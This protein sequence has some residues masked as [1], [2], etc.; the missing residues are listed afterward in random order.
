[1]QSVLTQFHNQMRSIPIGT[2]GMVTAPSMVLKRIRAG[3][4]RTRTTEPKLEVSKLAGT[5]SNCFW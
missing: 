5:K 2:L 1:M 4:T 3:R